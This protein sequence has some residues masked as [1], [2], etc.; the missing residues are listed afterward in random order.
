MCRWKTVRTHN[1]LEEKRKELVNYALNIADQRQFLELTCAAL[2]ESCRETD[3]QKKNSQTREVIR[4]IK[5]KM[6]F[7][8][9]NRTN[10]PAG[11]GCKMIISFPFVWSY[12]PTCLPRNVN[13]PYC[14]YGLGFPVKKSPRS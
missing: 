13:S 2:E 7:T 1:R 5:Q 8:G 14:C 12:C 4:S 6:S 10:L 3:P 9:K 11:G